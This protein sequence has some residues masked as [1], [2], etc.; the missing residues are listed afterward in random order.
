M[1]NKAKFWGKKDKLLLSHSISLK[2]RSNFAIIYSRLGDL[3]AKPFKTSRLIEFV[4]ST[5]T[6]GAF[7]TLCSALVKVTSHKKLSRD[8]E[9]DLRLERGDVIPQPELMDEAAALVHR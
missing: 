1:E 4:L 9:L 5:Q 7:N 2:I 6:F 8:L 3:L